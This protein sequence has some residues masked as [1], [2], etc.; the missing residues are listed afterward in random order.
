MAPRWPSWTVSTLAFPACFTRGRD[1]I[2]S[3]D[4]HTC[5]I[6]SD[7]MTLT[8]VSTQQSLLYQQP[9]HLHFLYYDLL[10]ALRLG[11]RCCEADPLGESA[12]TSC[13]LNFHVPTVNQLQKTQ[14]RLHLGKIG[15]V[16]EV[17]GNHK[18][19]SSAHR[20]DSPPPSPPPSPAN[21]PHTYIQSPSAHIKTQMVIKRRKMSCMCQETSRS[22]YASPWLRRS[23]GTV[24]RFAPSSGC[25]RLC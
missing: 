4:S 12:T 14:S 7:Q 18:A 15:R 3:D 17:H 13:L 23:R 5:Q 25:S 1:Q 8:H 11:M 16:A 10:R 24:E 20:L 19:L 2:R 9:I 6:R 22:G 21:T